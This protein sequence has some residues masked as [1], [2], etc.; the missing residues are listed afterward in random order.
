M[1]LVV[2][3]DPS[4][5]CGGVKSCA[6]TSSALIEC[7]LNSGSCSSCTMNSFSFFLDL[8]N[9]DFTADSLFSFCILVI[10]FIEKPPISKS[11]IA[12]RSFLS[13][14]DNPPINNWFSSKKSSVKK[15][16]AA[17]PFTEFSDTNLLQNGLRTAL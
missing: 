14:R 12:A 16:N 10:S 1:S 5:F 3:V 4:L 7:L 6:F 13:S 17:S 2:D 15:V 8:L 9:R 11:S